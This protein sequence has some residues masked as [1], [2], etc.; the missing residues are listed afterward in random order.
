MGWVS[1]HGCPEDG[2]HAYDARRVCLEKLNATIEA[3]RST[4]F[5][6]NYEKFIHLG[7]GL[8]GINFGICQ[9]ET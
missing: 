6:I 1:P 8:F 7:T 3:I 4:I 2:Q 9:L 5:R